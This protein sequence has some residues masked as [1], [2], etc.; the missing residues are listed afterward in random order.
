MELSSSAHTGISVSLTVPGE[1]WT[2]DCQE[3]TCEK[4]S[5][6]VRCEPKRCH[7]SPTPLHCPFEGFVSISTLSPEDKCCPRQECVC[8]TTYCPKSIETCP[9]GYK[10][11]QQKLPGD[12]CLS[13]TCEK[14]PGCVVNETFYKPGAVIPRG[15]CETCRCS[16]DED[17]GSKSN[18]IVCRSQTCDRSCPEGHKYKEIPG[19]CCGHCVPV[20]CIL[21]LSPTDSKVIKP[22][23]TWYHPEDNC[24]SYQCERIEDKYIPVTVKISCPP[25]NESACSHDAVKLTENGCCKTCPPVEQKDCGPQSI[26][27][28]IKY[29]GCKSSSSVVL[30]YCEGQ[31]GSSSKYSYKANAMDHN[32]SCC[33]EQKTSKKH[34]T[35]TCLDGSTIDYSYI[36]VEECACTSSECIPHPSPTPTQQQQQ[37]Q[38]EEEPQQEVQQQFEQ[39]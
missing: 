27:T 15:P 33:Q 10:L 7:V 2:S 3:C 14:V 8:N 36:Y 35:L 17:P 13:T 20:A 29:N 1:T 26:P 34:V 18:V 6:I 22:G 9:P 37:Q 21:K 30:T 19:E 5:L 32:C 12:C 28:V 25:F 23:E 16:V 4:Y 24:T 31:C 39:K 11:K 38:Q